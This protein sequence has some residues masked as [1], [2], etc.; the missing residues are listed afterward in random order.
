V[1]HIPTDAKAIIEKA[2][3]G[4]ELVK[5][6][7]NHIIKKIILSLVTHYLQE[8]LKGK[9]DSEMFIWNS[10]HADFNKKTI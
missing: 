3:G 2:T 4:L 10:M 7:T 8:Q 9:A 5:K 6:G 1:C